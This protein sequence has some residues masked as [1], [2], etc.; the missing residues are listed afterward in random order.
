MHASDM[1]KVKT[2]NTKPPCPVNQYK[3]LPVRVRCTVTFNRPFWKT[4]FEILK[5]GLPDGVDYS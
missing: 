5:S 4:A 2:L 3:V 1:V